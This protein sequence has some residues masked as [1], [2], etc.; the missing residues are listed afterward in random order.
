MPELANKG[1]VQY[2]ALYNRKNTFLCHLYH[3][4]DQRFQRPPAIPIDYFPVQVEVCDVYECQRPNTPNLVVPMRQADEPR[5]EWINRSIHDIVSQCL[6]NPALRVHTDQGSTWFWRCSTFMIPLD[7]HEVTQGAERG[8]NGVAISQRQPSMT[9]QSTNVWL[10]ERIDDEEDPEVDSLSQERNAP[11]VF[12]PYVR[13]DGLHFEWKD[14]E[15][16]RTI[17]TMETQEDGTYSDNEYHLVFEVLG[18]Q[19]F[20]DHV[21]C[22]T[23]TRIVRDSNGEECNRVVEFRRVHF[24]SSDC[25]Q[26][27]QEI[28][29]TAFP[30]T[31][32]W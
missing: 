3:P 14:V 29:D 1:I 22:A 31:D 6:P 27:V 26:F 16:A 13:G 32:D 15:N 21:I 17:F 9:R 30:I 23:Q 20:D 2:G 11:D 10:Q 19:Y 8:S 24:E 5:A 4:D 18:P 28:G 12:R 7:S 25:V